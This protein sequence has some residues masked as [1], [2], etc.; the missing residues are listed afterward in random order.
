MSDEDRRDAELE[1][2]PTD[3]LADLCVKGGE[4]LV[5]QEYRRFH[6]KGA[7]ERHPLLL[8][9]GELVWVFLGVLGKPD[10]VEEL[11]GSSVA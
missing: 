1:L 4:R 3:L 7:G 5:E 9:A 2:N 11:L 8:S 6:R 10:D